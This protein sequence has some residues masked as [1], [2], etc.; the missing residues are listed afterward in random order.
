MDDFLDKSVFYRWMKLL[1]E[2]NYGKKGSPFM[3]PGI[4]IL[5]LAKLREFRGI[6]FRQLQSEL[7]NLLR[8]FK[9]PEINNENSIIL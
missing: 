2:N 1:E 6:S 9:F 5:Y 3:I 7:H 4:F 8:I